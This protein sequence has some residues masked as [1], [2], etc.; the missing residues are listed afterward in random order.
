[1][2]IGVEID[3]QFGKVEGFLFGCQGPNQGFLAAVGP[4][5][6][7]VASPCRA[8]VRGRVPVRFGDIGPTP[9]P[10]GWERHAAG[11]GDDLSQVCGGFLFAGVI[12][13][14]ECVSALTRGRGGQARQEKGQGA[15]GQG[16]DEPEGE[17]RPGQAEGAMTAIAGESGQAQARLAP[18]DEDVGGTQGVEILQRVEGDKKEGLRI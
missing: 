9:E 5:Q 15:A 7:G 16:L 10:K 1:M 4:E 8:V 3:L 14:I 6:A 11:Q 2:T 13:A 12:D 18:R 17:G